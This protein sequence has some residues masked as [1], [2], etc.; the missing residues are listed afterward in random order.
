M[1]ANW[2]EVITS[3][4]GI[5]WEAAGQRDADSCQLDSRALGGRANGTADCCGISGS[6]TRA[7]RRLP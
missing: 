2:K 4:P 7:N 3:D 6:D 5:L 1:A